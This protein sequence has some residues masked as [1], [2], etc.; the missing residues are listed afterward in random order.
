L[1]DSIESEQ[2]APAWLGIPEQSVIGLL[3]DADF[4]EPC[5]SLGPVERMGGLHG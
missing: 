3:V 2:S 5:V 1:I 4:A